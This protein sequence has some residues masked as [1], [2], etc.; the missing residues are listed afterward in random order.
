MEK[1]GAVG[2]SLERGSGPLRR[3][4]CEEGFPCPASGA[5]RKGEKIALREPEAARC[6]PV[7]SQ[8]RKGVLMRKEVLLEM[9]E[10]QDCAEKKK[11][12]RLGGGH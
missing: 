5:R 10:N 6:S 11:K 1:V 4:K 9:R 8:V 12:F 3:Q 7:K 2:R